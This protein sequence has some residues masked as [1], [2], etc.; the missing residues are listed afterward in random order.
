MAITS[1]ANKT[2]FRTR[3]PEKW[4]SS[5]T[6]L[7]RGWNYTVRRMAP[8]KQRYR[9]DEITFE[10]S[11]QQLADVITSMPHFPDDE[12]RAS[13]EFDW[14]S[15]NPCAELYEIW[16]ELKDADDVDHLDSVLDA[17]YDWADDNRVWIAP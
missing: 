6:G 3:P 8:I 17:L 14:S 7:H 2:W 12:E 11:R 15:G 10:Q 5:P 13:D 9:D 1:L 16:D 4:S